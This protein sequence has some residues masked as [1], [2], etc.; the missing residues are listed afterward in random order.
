MQQTMNTIKNTFFANLSASSYWNSPDWTLS[1]PGAPFTTIWIFYI[2]NFDWM[3]AER[4]NPFLSTN[5]QS[6]ANFSFQCVIQYE[7]TGKWSL[8]WIKV[9]ETIN[10]PN[11]IHTNCLGQLGGIKIKIFMVNKLIIHFCVY[12]ACTSRHYRVG[13]PN[14]S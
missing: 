5:S 11:A 2:Y 14:V 1:W 7:E 8:V 13:F 4:I 9:S 12:C 3:K 10:S 6:K